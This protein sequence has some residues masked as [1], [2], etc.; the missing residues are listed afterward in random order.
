MALSA[1]II[2]LISPGDLYNAGFQLSFITTLAI[3]Y[4]APGLMKKMHSLPKW[5]S[6]VIAVSVAAQIGSAP[7]IAAYFYRFS[8]VS[9]AA[10]VIITPLVSAVTVLGMITAL[11]S[12]VPGFV[13]EAVA[14]LNWIFLTLLLQCVRYL[15]AIPYA[16]IAVSPP[17]AVF[18]VCYYAFTYL[19]GRALYVQAGMAKL[20]SV[21][22]TA[23]AVCIGAHYARAECGKTSLMVPGIKRCPAAV[24][25]RN[26][27]KTVVCVTGRLD[28]RDARSSVVRYIYYKGIN[29][30]DVLVVNAQWTDEKGIEI[31]LRKTNVK[32]VIVR[33]SYIPPAGVQFARAGK[34]GV[35]DLGVGW[36][37]N[38]SEDATEVK[39]DGSTASYSGGVWEVYSAGELKSECRCGR[40]GRQKYFKTEM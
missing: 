26:C 30:V 5:L 18:I 22:V 28:A 8:F 20:V 13:A 6:A 17:S 10:N 15:A 32:R 2:L 16:S 36:S 12:F 21:A 11:F 25:H 19:A 34:E 37:V 14:A 7:V 9:L 33:G 31:I 4:L 23:L 40:T 38:V 39:V 35:F 24:I 29:S 1:L 27:S 3:I